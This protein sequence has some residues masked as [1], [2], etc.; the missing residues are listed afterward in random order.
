MLNIILFQP[1]I[2]ANTGNIARTCIGFNARLHL[3]RPYGFI[4]S[5]SNLKRSGVDYWDK[6]ELYEYD[7]F[8]DFLEKNNHPNI[9]IYT[10]YG[11]KKPNEINYSKNDDIYIMFGKE[12]TGVPKI[13]LNKY[14]NNLIR[15]PTSKNIRSL[16]LSNTVAIACYEVLKQFN[17]QGLENLEPHKKGYIF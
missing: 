16:N 5:D 11:S 13:I 7:T 6:L 10:R 15:I 8:D 12:S 1:E 4:L 14:I 2:P 3:I 17:Y 9:F